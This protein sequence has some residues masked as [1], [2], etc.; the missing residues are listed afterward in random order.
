MLDVTTAGSSRLA[1][2]HSGKDMRELLSPYKFSETVIVKP[3]F[4]DRADGYIFQAKH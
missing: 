3:N 1:Y 2:V 4:V